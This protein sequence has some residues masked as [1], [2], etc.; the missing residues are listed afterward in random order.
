MV[1]LFYKI[2]LIIFPLEEV[3]GVVVIGVFIVPPLPVA[4]VVPVV[5]GVQAVHHLLFS[6]NFPYRE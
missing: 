1:I 4:P 6:T 5:E 2:K 3:N